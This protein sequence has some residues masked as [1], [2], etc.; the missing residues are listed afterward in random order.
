MPNE[1]RASRNDQMIELSYRE[2]TILQLFYNHCGEVLDR[3]L[4]FNECWGSDYF[5]N[6]RTL[7]QHISKLRKHIEVDSSNPKLIQTV[8][9]RGYRYHG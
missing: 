8:H 5:P 7:D 9:G 2:I 3:D 6:S 1:L 4:L